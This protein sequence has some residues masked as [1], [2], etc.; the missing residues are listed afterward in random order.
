MF[1]D[2]Q[3]TYDSESAQFLPDYL[4]LQI[5]TVPRNEDNYL[6]QEVVIEDQIVIGPVNTH[7]SDIIIG[8]WLPFN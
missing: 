1:I 5:I 6:D 2:A 3:N 7:C 4:Q 8:L